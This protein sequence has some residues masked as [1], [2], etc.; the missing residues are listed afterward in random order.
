MVHKGKGAGGSRLPAWEKQFWQSFG[1]LEMWLE[2][3][4][5]PGSTLPCRSR[6][7]QDGC[8]DPLVQQSYSST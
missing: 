5:G 6:F 3:G 8:G 7:V 1:T 4:L 2:M